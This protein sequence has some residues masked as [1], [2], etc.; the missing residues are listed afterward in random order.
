MT[1]AGHI[2]S[3]LRITFNKTTFEVKIMTEEKSKGKS[4][5]IIIESRKSLTVSG[6]TDIDRFDE[7]I[8]VLF[9]ELGELT[10][11][12]RDLHVNRISVESGDLIVEGE[13]GAVIYGGKSKY[14]PGFLTKLF[15]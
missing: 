2:F 13:I 7:N 15:K 1:A 4:Q 6:V 9:T 8:I 11:K 12:G 14:S 5:N 3:S 10:V